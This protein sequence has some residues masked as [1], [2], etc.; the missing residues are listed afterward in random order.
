M[1]SE[2]EAQ[3]RLNKWDKYLEEKEAKKEEND[4]D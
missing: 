4:S 3:E 2:A 1:E